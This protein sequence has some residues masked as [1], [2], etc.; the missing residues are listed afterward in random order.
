M[1]IFKNIVCVS[2]AEL[3]KSEEN[4]LGVMSISYYKKIVG[5]KQINVIRRG[6]KGTS[7]LIEFGSLPMKYQQMFTAAWGDPASDRNFKPFAQRLHPDINAQ[8]VFATYRYNQQSLPMEVQQAYSNDASI[9]NTIKET[10]EEMQ[11]AR[12]NCRLSMRGSWDRIHGLVEGIREL[13]TPNNIPKTQISLKR[14]Y[15]KYLAEGY[16]SLI[17]SNYGNKNAS[18]VKETDTQAE[19]IL[20]DLC[21]HGNQL[22]APM[23]AEHYNIW[24]EANDR[25]IMTSRSVVNFLKEHEVEIMS[26]RKGKKAWANKYDKVVAR[27]RPSAPLL[28]INSDDNDLDLYFKDGKNNYYR[29][30]VYVILDAHCDYILGWAAGHTITKEVIYEA[31]RDALRHIK[32]ITGDYYLWHQAVADH[33]GLKSE[34]LREFFQSLSIFTPAEA[35]LARSKVIERSFGTTWHNNLKQYNNYAGHN[36]T[37]KEKHNSDF[38]QSNLKKFPDISMAR[39]QIKQHIEAMRNKTWLE[40]GKTRREVWMENFWTNTMARQ[41]CISKELYLQKLGEHHEFSNTITNRG[42]RPTIGGITYTYDI[43]DAIY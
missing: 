16:Y 11:Q 19:A 13:Y 41:H 2:G 43:P 26:A 29:P 32:E 34:K 17:H 3:I 7:A 12:G 33:W 10:F 14:K 38:V 20:L 23:I 25:K 8:N 30:K 9:F 27:K 21:K 36:I 28:L 6:C 40:T 5:L 15:C 1:A 31:H 35:G 4:P 22:P 39:T 37:A 18:N 24:A 42:I